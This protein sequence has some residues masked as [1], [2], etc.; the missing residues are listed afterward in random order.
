[1][2]L[3]FERLVNDSNAY[4][5]VYDW[6]SQKVRYDDKVKRMVFNTA[7]SA[8]SSNPLNLFLKGPSSSGKTYCVMNIVRLFP[9]KH[10]WLLGGLSPT[11]IAHDYGELMDADGNPITESMLESM[12]REERRR[13][14]REAYIRVDLTRKILV[15]LEPPPLETYMRL[16]PILSHDAEEVSYK[17]T[18]KTGKAGTLRTT[19]VKIRGFP[20]TIHCVS[21]IKY[22]EDLATR[23]ITVTPEESREKF[24]AAHRV[25][26]LK[27][28]APENPE[29]KREAETI[30][31]WVRHILENSYPIYNPFSTLLAEVFPISM[32]RDMRDFEKFL[33]LIEANAILHRFHRPLFKAGNVSFQSVIR[34]DVEDT[35]SLWSNI[36]ETTRYGISEGSIILY[37]KVLHPLMEK[38]VSELTYDIITAKY[39]EVF[40][41]ALPK[42]TLATYVSE[43][44]SVGWVEVHSHPADKR[45]RVVYP[46]KE[47]R[48]EVKSWFASMFEKAIGSRE[49]I[50][51]WFQVI[52][53][54]LGSK[55]EI[56]YEGEWVEAT[57]DLLIQILVFSNDLDK[58]NIASILYGKPYK[59]SMKESELNKLFFD[60]SKLQTS[61]FGT[62]QKSHINSRL[63]EAEKVF[64]RKLYKP[65]RK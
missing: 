40:Q 4:E 48:E 3:N 28:Y 43:L 12:E 15:F 14:L 25:T 5:R 32:R 29:R 44:E 2:D 31:E 65:P 16:R 10:V 11:A 42:S 39:K 13:I 1:M 20:A 45:K 47:E 19:H 8:W 9:K 46:I 57:S 35:V 22:I 41:E 37:D 18:E 34:K 51:R 30:R 61:R 21:N 54:N 36:L 63:R 58:L 49:E 56:Y 26:A 7:V 23:S 55:P 27:T 62:L 60:T 64:L 24:R 33:T 6:V 38:G 59:E 53:S 50:E 17:F 52:S